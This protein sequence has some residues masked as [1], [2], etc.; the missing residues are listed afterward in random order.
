MVVSLKAKN[1]QHVAFLS[2]I[3]IQHYT[4]QSISRENERHEELHTT[5][6]TYNVY[7]RG[8]RFSEGLSKLIEILR[9]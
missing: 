3:L 5:I 7:R 1:T 4:L 6:L 8:R 9:I 2:K